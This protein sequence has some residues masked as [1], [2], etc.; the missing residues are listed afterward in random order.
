MY[1]GEVENK[2]NV[3][4]HKSNLYVKMTRKKVFSLVLFLSCATRMVPLNRSTVAQMEDLL[5]RIHVVSKVP[6][7]NL[8]VSRSYETKCYKY[9]E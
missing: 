6:R 1:N 5:V 3:N 9:S 7:L 4:L 8:T 2:E